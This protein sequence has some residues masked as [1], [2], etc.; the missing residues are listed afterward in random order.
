[1][2]NS[3]KTVI[4]FRLVRIERIGENNRLYKDLKRIIEPVFMHINQLL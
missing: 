3:G 4:I 1:M 2:Y